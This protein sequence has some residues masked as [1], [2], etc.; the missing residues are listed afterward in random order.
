ML[1][2]CGTGKYSSFCT[3]FTIQNPTCQPSF[4]SGE[5]WYIGT[6]AD[7]ISCKGCCKGFAHA[8]WD[9]DQMC[10][11]DIRG[12]D[13]RVL[14]DLRNRDTGKYYYTG[15]WIDAKSLAVRCV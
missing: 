1:L 8:G 4:F 11:E 10:P 3:Q 12:F 13:W 14:T 6:K 15:T 2:E 7:F 9:N 5:K